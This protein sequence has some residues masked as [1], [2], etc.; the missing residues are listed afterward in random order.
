M[1]NYALL[2]CTIISTFTLS[3]SIQYFVKPLSHSLP[4][5]I[6]SVNTDFIFRCQNMDEDN[7]LN[8]LKFT[9]TIIVST[10]HQLGCNNWAIH[11]TELNCVRWVALCLQTFQMFTALQHFTFRF[12]QCLHINDNYTHLN[13]KRCISSSHYIQKAR[14]LPEVFQHYQCCLCSQSC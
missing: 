13:L 1:C 9:R 14:G 6:H 10:K 12:C 7:N 11:V 2:F 4:S 8:F 5:E 3:F